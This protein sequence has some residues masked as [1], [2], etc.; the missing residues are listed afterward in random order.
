MKNTT[1]LIAPLALGLVAATL[2]SSALAA[3]TVPG[4]NG[5]DG[6]LNI[7]A[8]TVI[9]LSQAPTGA[10]NNDNTPNA[11]KGVYDPAKWAVVFKYTSVTVAAGKTLTFKNHASRAP[12]AW[13]VSGNVT[14]NGT[15]SLDGGSNQSVPAPR[16]TEPGP[17][18]FRGGAGTYAQS[19]SNGAGFGVGGG[20]SWISNLHNGGN[21]SYGSV[22]GDG[23]PLS[24]TAPVYGN[25]S[26]IPLIGGSGGGGWPNSV[27]GTASGAGGGA[28]LIA[29]QNTIVLAGTISAN[30]GD[31]D[32]END[33]FGP[34]AA[35]GS[36]GGIRII[37][38]VFSGSGLAEATGGSG[39]YP[40]PSGNGRI[41]LERVTNSNTI[42]VVP[43]PSVVDLAAGTTALIWPPAGAPEVKIVSLGGVN[44]PADPRAGFG[45]IGA[46]V[47]LPTAATTAAVIETTNVES[48]SQ[49]KVRITPRDTYNYTEVDA[50][51]ASTVSTS[52]LVL[53]WNA[54]LPT[55]L[56]YSAVQV[57]VIRP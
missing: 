40:A 42:S 23:T 37:T 38:D 21:G 27:S 22:G 51:L 17:G 10:W 39:S 43:A 5:T 28:I 46:D 49:V 9:D 36:G 14:I 15:V 11:G 32:G 18:G 57:K 34:K 30:G 54:T 53:R 8:D 47:S 41:R 25:P 7:T 20:K 4:A 1:R 45:T 12:V 2:P 55:K 31:G 48:A 29:A 35:S 3:I 19:V 50:T 33:G 24:G 56:G 6:A 52:P 26:L 44:A 16:L 13:L